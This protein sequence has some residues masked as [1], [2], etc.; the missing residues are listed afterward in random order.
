MLGDP[1]AKAAGRLTLNPLAH[2]DLIGTIIFPVFLFYLTSRMGSPFVFGWAKPVPVNFYN[3]R[4][5]KRDMM[6]V[7]LAGPASNLLM[8]IGIS[9]LLKIGLIPHNPIIDSFILI[10]LILAVFNIIP[11]PPLDGSRVLMGLL[12]RDYARS[13]SRLEPY[14]FIV[15]IAL[16]YLGVLHAVIWPIVI[17]LSRILGIY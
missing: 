8:A 9:I 16:I 7:G 11:V 2:I 5:P 6:W 1:T 15:L 4:N 17:Y 14:G 3:L 13:Y 10:N 12:P